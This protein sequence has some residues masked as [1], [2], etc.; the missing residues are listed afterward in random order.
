MAAKE[1]SVDDKIKNFGFDFSDKETNANDQSDIKL[2]DEDEESRAKINT[3]LDCIANTF[4]VEEQLNGTLKKWFSIFIL[5]ILLILSIVISAVVILEGFK[6]YGFD[7]EEWTLRLF[8]S[9]VFLEIIV[10]IK[11]MINSLF[12]KDDRK[13]YLDF[14]KECAIGNDGTNKKKRT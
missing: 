9:G 11:I 5:I 2:D 6:L 7:L 1:N 12:P 8:V 10:L 13:L 4:P 14:I 3:L